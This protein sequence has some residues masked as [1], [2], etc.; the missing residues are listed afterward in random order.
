ML[1]NLDGNLQLDV[2]MART[3]ICQ[4]EQPALVTK[5]V[6]GPLSLHNNTS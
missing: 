4:C 2:N 3:S 5:Q 6:V 1:Y